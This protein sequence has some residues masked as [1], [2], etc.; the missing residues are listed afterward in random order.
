MTLAELKAKY[1]LGAGAQYEPKPGCRH[2]KG[3]G[4]RGIK[5]RHH[6]KAFCICLYVSHEASDEIGASLG[7]FASKEL[8]KFK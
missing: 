1:S 5:S 3:V 7:Q 6:E 4:E 8:Q 2:C